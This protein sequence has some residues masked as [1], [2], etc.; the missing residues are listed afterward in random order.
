LLSEAEEVVAVLD[1]PLMPVIL[2]DQVVVVQDFRLI[3]PMVMVFS[4]ANLDL[5]D[6]PM[7]MEILVRLLE[8]TEQ[9]VVVEQEVLLRVAREIL[10]LEV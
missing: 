9:M 6:F 3:Q 1:I 4:L 5:A 2:G 7:V 10:V 8:I